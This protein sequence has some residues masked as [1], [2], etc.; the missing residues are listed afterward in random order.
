MEPRKPYLQLEAPHDEAGSRPTVAPTPKYRGLRWV[1]IGGQGL[2]AG[3]SVAIFVILTILFCERWDG[4]HRLSS[5]IT[6]RTV[7]AILRPQ[8]DSSGK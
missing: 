8:G 4:G 1:F 6:S 5:E 3:W 2:R 7:P